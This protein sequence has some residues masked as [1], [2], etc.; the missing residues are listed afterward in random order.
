[1]RPRAFRILI[2][3]GSISTEL[4]QQ[5]KKGK[6]IKYLKYTLHKSIFLDYIVALDTTRCL[7]IL[8]YDCCVTLFS[9]TSYLKVLVVIAIRMVKI[10]KI[11][12]RDY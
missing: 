12:F 10:V 11:V 7:L 6:F 1:M 8:Y 4:M 3:H 5:K 2:T 9:F